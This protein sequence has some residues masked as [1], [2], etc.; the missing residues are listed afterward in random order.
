[1]SKLINKHEKKTCSPV[2]NGAGDQFSSR[3]IHVCIHQ[4]GLIIKIAGSRITESWSRSWHT[5]MIQLK[6]HVQWSWC[7]LVAWAIVLKPWAI[8]NPP[9][10]RTPSLSPPTTARLGQREGP[11][12]ASFK[13]WSLNSDKKHFKNITR[14]LGQKNLGRKKSPVILTRNVSIISQLD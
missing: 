2:K 12:G 3:F 11:E 1:M 6:D 9:D 8:L 10:W 4:G 5:I 13:R 14:G 7:P